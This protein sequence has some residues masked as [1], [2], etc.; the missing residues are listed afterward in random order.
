MKSKVTRKSKED[1]EVGLVNSEK[2]ISL[3]KDTE[4]NEFPSFVFPFAD[5]E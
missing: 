1:V 5:E 4:K 2:F 3:R